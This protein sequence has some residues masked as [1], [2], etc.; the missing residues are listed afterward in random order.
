MGDEADA[1]VDRMSNP[2]PLAGVR[3]VRCR[4]DLIKDQC[5]L[6]TPR[7]R[8]APSTSDPFG[9]AVSLEDVQYPGS[10]KGPWITARFD[11]EC[12][13]CDGALW[14]GDDIRADGSGGWEGRCCE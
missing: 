12:S 1:I 2:N 8:P 7:T 4:H 3:V 13:G 10:N 5:G 9:S 14:E 6:C 11:S